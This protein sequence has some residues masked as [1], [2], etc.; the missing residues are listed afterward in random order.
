MFI[1]LITVAGVVDANAPDREQQ[2]QQQQPQ[3]TDEKPTPAAAW[4]L[5]N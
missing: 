4:A 2:Q 3:Q 5:F 1:G